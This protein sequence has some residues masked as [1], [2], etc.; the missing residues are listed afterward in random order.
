MRTRTAAPASRQVAIFSANPETL[1]GLEAYL[2]GVGIK[3]KGRRR[4]EECSELTSASTMAIVVFPDDFAWEAVLASVGELAKTCSSTLRL[5]VTGQPK[6][7]ERLVDGKGNVMVVPRPV[8]GWTILD[9]IR[10]HADRTD[11]A[12]ARARRRGGT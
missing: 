5:L 3:A 12:P 6:K 10:A 11:D 4:L 7:Y 8:W 1:D 2:H 9:A